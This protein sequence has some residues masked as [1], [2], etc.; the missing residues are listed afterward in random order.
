MLLTVSVP[1]RLVLSAFDINTL[2]AKAAQ[3]RVLAGE[4]HRYN[5]F[6]ASPLAIEPLDAAV[7]DGAVR[8]S[9]PACAV[10]AITVEA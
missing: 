6:E 1:A 5:D 10:A 7:K 4:M 3:G 2:N 9:L 8:V